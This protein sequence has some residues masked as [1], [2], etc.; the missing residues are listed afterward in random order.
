MDGYQNHMIREEARSSHTM[1]AVP[2]LF[3][4]SYVSFSWPRGGEGGGVAGEAAPRGGS[5]ARG[6][7]P[8]RLALYD[9]VC[10]RDDV[11]HQDCIPSH[12]E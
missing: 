11:S 10:S 7:P 1:H 5:G 3:D 2:R 6:A 9:E 12:L 8:P 4:S